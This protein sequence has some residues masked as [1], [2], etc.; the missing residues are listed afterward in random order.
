MKQYQFTPTDGV[1]RV[2]AIPSLKL[3]SKNLN[4]PAESAASRGREGKTT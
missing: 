3:Y 2:V 1:N 4:A